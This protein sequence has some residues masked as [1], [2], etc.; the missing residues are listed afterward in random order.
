[1]MCPAV[2]IAGKKVFLLSG[3]QRLPQVVGDSNRSMPIQ[4]QAM[5]KL[6]KS[7]SAHLMLWRSVTWLEVG[8]L[9]PNDVGPFWSGSLS[10][11]ANSN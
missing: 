7:A 3:Y 2:E 4:I 8:C 11:I 10:G 9:S 6:R 5:E 1:M